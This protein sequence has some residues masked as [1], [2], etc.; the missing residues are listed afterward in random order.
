M[1]WIKASFKH[2]KL[3]LIAGGPK[4]GVLG[5]GLVVVLALTVQTWP[6][7]QYAEWK[8]YDES[9][10]LLRKMTHQPVTNDVIII[11]ADEESFRVFDEPFALWH[12][13]LGALIDAMV[14]AQ[15][16]ALGFDIVLPSKSFNS[17]VPDID[18]EL[19]LPLLRARGKLKLVVV[20][21]LDD[22]LQPRP[23]FAGFVALIGVQQLASGLVCFDEDSV[24]RRVMSA[25]C[26]SSA[27]GSDHQG[28]AERMGALLGA[29]A[30]GQGLIDFRTGDA[31]TTISMAQV[32]RWQAEGNVQKLR[33]T[34]A[35]R[36]VLAGV[37]LPLEDRLRVPVAMFAAEPDNTR[38]PGVMLHAQILR[39]LLNH[40][41]IKTVPR[42]FVGVLTA[43]VCLCWFGYGFKKNLLYWTLFA[44]LPIIGLY[45]LWLG[46]ALSPAAL[47]VSA[48]LAYV[49]RQGLEAMRLAHQRARLTQAFAGH[50]NP[51]LLQRVLS[52]DLHKGVGEL[53]PRRQQ[54]T[55]MWV[56]IPEHNPVLTD[57]PPDA[58]LRSLSKYFDAVQQAV[59]R[60]GGM[61][62]RFQGTGVLAY[63]GAPLPL[64]NP[65]RAALEAALAITRSHPSWGAAVSRQAGALPRLSIGVAT[66]QVVT[67]QAPMNKS[68]PFVVVGEPVDQA[69]QLAAQAACNEAQSQVLVSAATAAAVGEAGMKR[70][71]STSAVTSSATYLL[72]V[73]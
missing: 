51:R 7:F 42:W 70:L 73:S 57:D 22:D 25:H 18:R 21:T 29:P 3:W 17:V 62:D 46:Y 61:V 67:G 39:S 27:N 55:V 45:A 69:V 64:R 8:L 43:L 12:K 6:G 11:A 60:S 36:A 58:A 41:Y 4:V 1:Q 24:V 19:M 44:M 34:F 63:F 65:A 54:A 40:G 38:V 53:A 52:S 9:L 23:I 20:Q 48:K 26:G 66:G 47:L 59:Q 72:T 33:E 68:S 5:Y 30:R 32:L 14:V 56:Q 10:K 37:A 49:A 13:R 15:P 28:L 31:F 2:F 50:V 71:D 35:G 16:A